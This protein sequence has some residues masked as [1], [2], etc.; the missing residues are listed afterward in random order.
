MLSDLNSAAVCDAT[1]MECAGLI[2]YRYSIDSPRT[3][4]KTDYIEKL[5]K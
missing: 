4:Q 5:R 3:G 1:E 2:Y